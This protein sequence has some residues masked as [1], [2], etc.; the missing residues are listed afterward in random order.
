MRVPVP[1]TR[2]LVLSLA[3]GLILASGSPVLRGEPSPTGQPQGG[4]K[5]SARFSHFP[6]GRAVPNLDPE[7]PDTVNAALRADGD[8]SLPPGF[9]VR[10]TGPSIARANGNQVFRFDLEYQGVPLAASSDY[11]AVVGRSG[12]ILAT[13]TR[14]LPVSVDGA[15]AATPAAV[16][17]NLA[18]SHARDTLGQSGSLTAS[19]PS[20]EIWV[21]SA[22][23]GHLSWLTIVREGAGV[24]A[25][26]AYRISAIGPP[27][28]LSAVNLR[29]Y[30][31]AIHAQSNVW[32][33]SPN[34]PPVVAPLPHLEV[35]A[36]GET[37]LTDQA[38]NT[39]F[40]VLLPGSGA[41]ASLRGPFAVVSTDQGAPLVGSVTTTGGTDILDFGAITEFELAQ[42]T[43]FHWA[44]F[45][46][47]WVRG[48]LP[49]LNTRLTN[50][51]NLSV[52]TNQDGLECNAFAAGGLIVFGAAGVGC[53]NFATATVVAHEF[54]HELHLAFM[55]DEFDSN[56]S[57]GF[58]DALAALVTGQPCLAPGAFTG[59]ERCL[60]DATEVTIFPAEFPDTHEQ[61]KPYAQFAWALA[62]SLG[63]DTAAQL[64]LG[65]AAAAPRDIPD[66]VYLSFVVDDDDGLL[67]TCSP[68]QEALEAAADSR[69]LPRPPDC[70]AAGDNGAP[71]AM[72]DAFTLTED[73]PATAIDVTANDLDPDGDRLIVTN[74]Q[75]GALGL[76]DCTAAGCSYLPNANAHGTDSFGYTVIDT[77]GGSAS[78][79]VRVTITAVDDAPTII[80]PGSVS[81]LE[82]EPIPV[83]ASV[84]DPDGP[85]FTLE[86]TASDGLSPA[87]CTFA[88]PGLATTMMT[89]SRD[90]AFQVAVVVRQGT[91]QVAGPVGTALIGNTRPSVSI[92]APV[93]GSSFPETQV[94]QVLSTFEE[95]P[96]A[97][98]HSC[99]IA[100]GDG[101]VTTG[102]VDLGT[103]SGSHTYGPGSAGPRQIVVTV[104]DPALARGAAS[105][106]IMIT[107]TGTACMRDD[108]QACAVA[109]AGIVGSVRFRLTAAPTA[110]QLVLNDGKMWGFEATVLTSLVTNGSTAAFSGT[111]ELDGEPGYRFE[112]SVEDNRSLGVP[113]RLRVVVR[114]SGGA[115]VRVVDG[116]V[117][118]GQIVVN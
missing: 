84:I 89:C 19:I 71:T 1:V 37:R 50:L 3:A 22:H 60:R 58:G 27:A 72:D 42:T 56:Y 51:D 55:Q 93:A 90:G 24:V 45:T 12:R 23:R 87:P 30:Q 116:E 25:S 109:G 105:V 108:G 5:P 29:Q 62:T 47:H 114:S 10:A 79:T 96:T 35:S 7:R 97:G 99:E 9:R 102:V 33:L 68:H 17:T 106:T 101:V 20:L 4:G 67:G 36:G 98:P 49:S 16:A 44:S 11:V 15:Q 38:G 110:G 86:W 61:G 85:A 54:G 81:G 113:D 111:G 115:V 92:A 117:S 32:Q 91:Q 41:F 112:A 70:R 8:R 107:S 94:V 103:C 53:N 13:R 21:D 39:V 31:A 76:V 2:C 80:G 26:T 6:G 48:Y 66:A 100:W 28:V 69:L 18:L 34:L 77:Y 40:P 95:G 14:G 88:N 75:Q 118:R 59:S 57:E 65:A 78:A 73:A 43:A 46:N 82:G 74:V 64:V 63:I 83:A 52:L 104:T